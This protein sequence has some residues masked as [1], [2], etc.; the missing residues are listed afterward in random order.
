VRDL[1]RRACR[2]R[3]GEAE[4]SPTREMPGR[5]GAALTTPGRVSIARWGGSGKR[6]EEEYARNRR[7][8]VPR[9]VNRL[10]PGGYGPGAVRTRAGAIGTGNF[11][12][13]MW[14]AVRKATVTCC[15]GSRGEAAGIELGSSFVERITVNAGTAPVLPACRV[16][17]TVCRAGLIVGRSGRGETEPP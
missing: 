10:K 13:A 3:N 14:V 6:D 7:D 2:S 5:V 16:A 4:G 9:K 8:D 11:R 1:R 15:G 12:T 17:N